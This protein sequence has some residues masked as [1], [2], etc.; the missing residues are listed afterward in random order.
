MEELSL[1]VDHW[2]RLRAQVVTH[3]SSTVDHQS[4]MALMVKH[5]SSFVDLQIPKVERRLPSSQILVPQ[6][7]GQATDMMRTRTIECLSL[8]VQMEPQIQKILRQSPWPKGNL[9]LMET[10]VI[11][12]KSLLDEL[13]YLLVV[14]RSGLDLMVHCLK[15]SPV[16]H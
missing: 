11:C 10:A 4:L 14:M 9:A 15:R 13:N 5:L 8:L 16:I 7:F 3:P 6:D 1:T 2:S 12:Q